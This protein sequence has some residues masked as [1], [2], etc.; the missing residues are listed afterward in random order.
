MRSNVSSPTVP[1]VEL[2]DFA[3]Y[4][5]AVFSCTLYMRASLV[6]IYVLARR[7]RLNKEIVKKVH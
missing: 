7:T 2:L 1:S 5:R 4:K 6:T 3:W